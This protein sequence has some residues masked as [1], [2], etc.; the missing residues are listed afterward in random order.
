MSEA[1]QP[2]SQHPSLTPESEV[3]ESQ[4]SPEI[5]VADAL[6]AE[7]NQLREQLQDAEERVLRA[8]AE[9]QNALRRAQQEIERARKFALESFV[10]D[11]LPVVDNLERAIENF[12]GIGEEFK[13]IVEG[14]EL[15]HKSLLSTLEKFQ[16]GAVDPVGENFNPEFHQAVSMVPSDSAEP[17]SVLQVFQKGY[18]LNGRLMRPAMVVVSKG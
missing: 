6:M 16:V 8:I 3:A 9:E 5:T 4:A 12:S 14:V 7:N 15:T 17:N 10:R 18:T 13:P 11:L 2:D 1:Q